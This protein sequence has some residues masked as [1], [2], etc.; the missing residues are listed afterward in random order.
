M[1][2]ANIGGRTRRMPL[3]HLLPVAEGV[4]TAAMEDVEATTLSNPRIMEMEDTGTVTVVGVTATMA[5]A[6]GD[7][8]DQVFN[9]LVTTDAQEGDATTT[10]PQPT[11]PPAATTITSLLNSLEGQ[12]TTTIL[13]AILTQDRAMGTMALTLATMATI[14]NSLPHRGPAPL[15]PTCPL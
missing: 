15:S 14:T 12:P 6:T 9:H 1:L 13:L 7:A 5:V 10:L 8:V 2:A 4:E 11:L 3:G